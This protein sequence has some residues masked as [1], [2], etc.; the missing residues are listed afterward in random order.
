MIERNAVRAVLLTPDERVL[1]LR[2]RLSG[3]SPFWIAPGGG[4]EPGETVHQALRRELRE[5]LDLTDFEAGPVL[6]LRQ[7]TFDWNGDRLCQREVY[8]AVHTRYFEPRMSD[9]LESAVLDEFR[10]WNIADLAHATER[11]TP[12]SLAAIVNSYL[13]DGPPV[14]SLSVEILED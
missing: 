6:W 13:R 12:L 2:I 9:Q 1:L 14:E 5:E 7:H 3:T 11:L 10:W 8:H 4:I